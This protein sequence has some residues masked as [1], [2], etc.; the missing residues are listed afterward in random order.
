MN[1][2]AHSVTAASPEH[3]QS[4][5]NILWH[6]AVFCQLALPFAA[7]T[8]AWR[9]EAGGSAIALEASEEQASPSGWCLRRLLMHICDKAARSH[10]PLVEMGADAAELA[11]EMGL[12]ATEPVL[13]ELTEQFERMVTAKMTVAPERHAALGVFDARGQ[14]RRVAGAWRSRIRL[15]TRFHASLTEHAV[16]L[17]RRIVGALAAEALALDAH[18]WIRCLLQGKAPDAPATV[19]WAELMERF[20][21]PG[22]DFA[23]FRAAFED[24]LRMVFAAD[25]SIS[26]AADD[27]GVTVGFATP[28]SATPVAPEPERVAE[29]PPP[30]A[31]REKAAA[32]PP[33]PPPAPEAEPVPAA[34]RGMP[35]TVSL[36]QHLTGLPVVVWLRRASGGEPPVI[37]VTRG[38][39][40]D[41]NQLTVLMLE[42]LIMQVSG[43]LYQ[44]EFDRVSAWI[45]AN[46]DLIDLVWE[47]KAGSFDEIAER[48]RKVQQGAGWR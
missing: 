14:T 12:P 47:G 29:P 7:S 17:D 8:G 36:R 4:D 26:L 39:R 44:E 1:H 37:G 45:M 3:G 40:L 23:A 5:P 30:P 43:G 38:P 9:R 13:R 41:Q 28:E 24:A 31:A 42:P 21:A 25:F 20:A 16:P 27:E 10:S 2:A 48:V 34:P 35:D 6:H 46:R 18:A 11:A 32:P 22:Q 15:N 33:P 19:P